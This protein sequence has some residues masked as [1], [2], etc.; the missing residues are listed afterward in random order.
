MCESE[1]HAWHL[2]LFRD[3]CSSVES[4]LLDTAWC[5]L[6]LPRFV[7]GSLGGAISTIPAPQLG[8]IAI[9][10]SLQRAR[11]SPEH[12]QAVY[13]G[14]V[15]SANIGQ[16]SNDFGLVGPL[17]AHF[18]AHPVRNAGAG[19]LSVMRFSSGHQMCLF[20]DFCLHKSPPASAVLCYDWFVLSGPCA[21]GCT[22]GRFTALRSVYHHQQRCVHFI[23]ITLA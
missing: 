2:I 17:Q 13:M 6:C 20:L 19:D 7:S 5:G 15:L 1:S 10:E 9:K 21:S 16:V 3:T 8:A 22:G 18:I 14:N 11:I 12:V 23:H 4:W